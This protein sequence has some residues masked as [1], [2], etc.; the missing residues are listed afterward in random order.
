M[1]SDLASQTELC[2]MKLISFYKACVSITEDNAKY[3]IVER[4]YAYWQKINKKLL[5]HLDQPIS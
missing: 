5:I 3:V 4:K 1:T 2:K